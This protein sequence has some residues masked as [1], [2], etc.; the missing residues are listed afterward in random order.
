M[1]MDVYY[2]SVMIPIIHEK[3][4]AVSPSKIFYN[5]H[6][7]FL[8]SIVAI[9]AGV[10]IFRQKKIGYITGWIFSFSAWVS[11]FFY[12]SQNTD[13]EKS[14]LVWYLIIS[15]LLIS[16]WIFF[17]IRLAKEKFFQ[18][19]TTF[20][21]PFSI[22]V[23]LIADSMIFHVDYENEKQIRT[24][25][26]RLDSIM[27]SDEAKMSREITNTVNDTTN[28][29]GKSMNELDG[30]TQKIE[31]QYVDWVCACAN[32]ATLEDIRK[33]NEKDSSLAKKCIF[34]E[35]ADSTIML[36]DTIGY[37]GDRIIFTGQFYKYKGYPKG[38]KIYEEPVNKARVFR[39]TNY[40]IV[41][42]YH[43]QVISDR[44]AEKN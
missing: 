15:F 41:K 4:Y 40:K 24:K 27:K 36:P 33:A 14:I 32:W 30:I 8:I 21:I 6:F 11:N 25:I 20:A 19:R 5:Y 31:L 16:L 17:S 43:N 13:V 3:N 23:I 39:Y 1:F 35:P 37:G 42:S 2:F 18:S 38:Y 34:I 29:L 9:F 22:V 28:A 12:L 10:Q 26:R 44:K 7:D